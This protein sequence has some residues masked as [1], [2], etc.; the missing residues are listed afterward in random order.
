MSIYYAAQWWS[1]VGK[2]TPALQRLAKRIVSQCCS[3]SSCERNWSTFALIHSK[4]RNRLTHRQLHKLV[5]VKYNLMLRLE[6]AGQRYVREDDDPF[7]KLMELS[8]CD[9]DI[10]PIKAWMDHGR[11]NATPLM[12]ED[13]TESDTP[14]P[15]HLVV[16]PD[17]DPSEWAQSN[18][19]DTH[20]GK[21]KTQTKP[22]CDQRKNKKSRGKK[23]VEVVESDE[24][25]HDSPEYQDSDGDDSDDGDDGDDGGDGGGDAVVDRGGS[26]PPYDPPVFTGM[27]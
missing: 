8:I 16:N 5:Y 20:I 18:V 15:S 23:P 2:E 9:E 6:E 7:R 25:T 4:L 24:E 1:V 17:I 26:S 14:L 27:I 13:D 22:R 19:G 11:S 3:S 21:R 10:N 12:D